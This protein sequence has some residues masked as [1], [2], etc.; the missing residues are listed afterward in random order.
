MDE[1]KR[2]L[3]R[4]AELS[5]AFLDGLPERHVGA[6][7]DGTT[8]AAGIGGP[9]P[10]EGQDATEVIETMARVLDPGLPLD[11]TFHIDRPAQGHTL[12][13]LCLWEDS[14]SADVAPWLEAQTV[15]DR[16]A[17][18]LRQTA[19]GWPGDRACDL[20]RYLPR[21]DTLVLYDSSVTLT[22]LAR[23]KEDGN[24]AVSVVAR[25]SGPPMQNATSRPSCARLSRN[26]ASCS[27]DIERPPTCSATT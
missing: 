9:L 21:E 24:G 10:E 4:A 12:G 2:A 14:W 15:L 20:E 19:L 25:P 7:V 26:F 23:A 27:L 18:W 3:R 17:D 13:N 22:G 16:I 1:R 6:T 8:L 11:L 5:E